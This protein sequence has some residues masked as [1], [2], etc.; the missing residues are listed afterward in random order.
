M[1]RNFADK[2]RKGCLSVVRESSIEVRQRFCNNVWDSIE[3]RCNLRD[4]Y[5]NRIHLNNDTEAIKEYHRYNDKLNRINR[6]RNMVRPEPR[7]YGK[8]GEAKEVSSRMTIKTCRHA[9]GEAYDPQDE[10]LL[11]QAEITK[12]ALQINLYADLERAKR[13]THPVHN[14]VLLDMAVWFKLI[15]YSDYEVL[16]IMHGR[17]TIDADI[18]KSYYRLGYIAY[19]DNGC[20]YIAKCN[21]KSK[22]KKDIYGVVVEVFLEDH[23]EVLV[24]ILSSYDF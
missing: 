17:F 3:L 24:P 11:T 4:R 20:F 10:L 16:N 9:P 15:G 22:D 7:Y 1:M 21:F 5:L 18:L 6:H 12:S 8:I 19:G 2:L 13:E 23:T 14:D